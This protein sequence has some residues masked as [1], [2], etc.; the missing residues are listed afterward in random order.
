MIQS[1][2]RIIPCLNVENAKYSRISWRVTVLFDS[3]SY[4][5]KASPIHKTVWSQCGSGRRYCFLPQ[6]IR[7]RIK[8]KT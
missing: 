7:I 5:F 1:L 2:M 3:S 4:L 8:T 6:V